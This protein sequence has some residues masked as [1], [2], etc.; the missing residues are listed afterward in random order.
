MSVF[1]KV[2]TEYG[3]NWTTAL[4]GWTGLGVFA[5]WSKGPQDWMSSSPLLY[6]DEIAAYAE[7]RLASSS[8]AKEQE[9]I[10]E[11]LSLNLRTETRGVI[12][13]ILV[14]LARLDGNDPAFEL[15]K[16]RL[17]LLE[18]LINNLPQ[19]FLHALI[20]IREFWQGFGYPSDSPHD[21]KD[22]GK[23]VLS[24]EPDTPETLARTLDRHRKWIAEE[25][26]V[27]KKQI[28]G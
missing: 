18:R 22:G 17:V 27:V 14:R 1:A 11:L 13:D 4:V 6:G 26:T 24:H 21:V 10:V 20:E 8:S 7:E 9:A 28:A 3:A 16:W 23:Q 19:D 12:R 15:R 2:K 5:P 25:K